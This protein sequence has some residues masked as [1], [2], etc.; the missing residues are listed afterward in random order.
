MGDCCYRCQSCARLRP[1]CVSL[2]VSRL[3]L[4][5][6][7]S[8]CVLARPQGCPGLPRGQ[9]CGHGGHRR[10]DWQM[11]PGCQRLCCRILHYAYA[12]LHT[13]VLLVSNCNVCFLFVFAE[14]DAKHI[15]LY[16]QQELSGTALSSVGGV[17]TLT[18]TR[19]LE[20]NDTKAVRCLLALCD[21]VFVLSFCFLLYAGHPGRRDDRGDMGCLNFRVLACSTFC[22]A[23]LSM[24]VRY[25]CVQG[26]VCGALSG[27]RR[28]VRWAAFSLLHC[29]CRS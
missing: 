20:P 17:T 15:L 8:V 11:G 25:P 24:I 6:S 29:T 14:A 5:V 9:R 27:G 1:L 4:D 28:R 18:F 26:P 13:I 3:T 12:A 16:P 19:V 22:V 21:L 7:V 23:S 10:C 2:C